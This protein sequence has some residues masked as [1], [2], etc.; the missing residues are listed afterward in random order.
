MTERAKQ[1]TAH[2]IG[3][4]YSR[5][6]FRAYPATTNANNVT[7]AAAAHQVPHF[8]SSNSKEFSRSMGLVLAVIG[9]MKDVGF[10]LELSFS[11]FGDQQDVLM[12]A[13]KS[14]PKRQVI[15]KRDFMLFL[16]LSIRTKTGETRPYGR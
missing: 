15:A 8:K 1:H 10:D 7:Y 14:R 12:F 6:L 9:A 16:L 4:L 5:H 2:P 3:A 11:V 13:Y